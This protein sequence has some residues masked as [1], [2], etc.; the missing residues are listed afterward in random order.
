MRALADEERENSELSS[1]DLGK[2]PRFFSKELAKM[3]PAAQKSLILLKK[4]QPDHPLFNDTIERRAI[5]WLWTERDLYRLLNEAY[6]PNHPDESSRVPSTLH[7]SPDDISAQFK[8]FDLDP[9]S[10][11]Y[12]SL[13]DNRFTSF[14]ESSLQSFL[15]TFPENLPPITPTLDHLASLIFQDLLDYSSQLSGALLSL[16]L[17][18]SRTL[19]IRANLELLRSY[20]LI[21]SST[22]K[23][24]LSNALFSD[25]G[26]YDLIDPAASSRDRFSLQNLRSPSSAPL[27]NTGRVSWAVGISQAL[28]DSG[29]WPP[30]GA[31]LNYVLR[32]VIVDSLENRHFNV[33][34][35]Q[36]RQ[37]VVEEAESRL[38]FAIRDLPTGRG[39]ERWLNPSCMVLYFCRS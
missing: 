16:L 33:D 21:S 35:D 25:A 20:L 28:L 2:P 26:D 30:V 14:P 1:L 24:K 36:A 37:D 5:Q 27:S 3:L 32:R 11:L 19:D 13:F 18:P 23:S 17:T 4:A 8:V 6:I 31:E 10:Q 12:Q 39:K 29:E 22:F 7:P 34:L 15:A 38:G 9:G